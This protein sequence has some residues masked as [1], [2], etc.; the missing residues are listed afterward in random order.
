MQRPISHSI[1]RTDK[2]L[3]FAKSGIA[4]QE[5]T[6][7]FTSDLRRLARLLDNDINFEED[8][9]GIS[10]PANSGYS[11]LRGS[12]RRGGTTWPPRS[13]NWKSALVPRGTDRIRD[14]LFERLSSTSLQD[15]E[16]ASCSVRLR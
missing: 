5:T 11:V 4:I 14:S 7:R 2:K 6:R 15:R 16:V 13:S 8:R 12:S 10:D 9:T 1:P 3:S